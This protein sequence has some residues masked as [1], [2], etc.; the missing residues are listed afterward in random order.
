[1]LRRTSAT[2]GPALVND[3][4][5]GGP[6]VHTIQRPTLSIT[7]LAHRWGVF[8]ATPFQVRFVVSL[9]T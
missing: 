4:V 7:Q 9:N 5:S 8:S 2:E 3:S 1:M 6:D